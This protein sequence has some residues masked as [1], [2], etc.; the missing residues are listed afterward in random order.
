[1]REKEDDRI[2]YSMLLLADAK[3][4]NLTFNKKLQDCRS[5]LKRLEW[6]RDMYGGI[7][8]CPVCS[9]QKPKHKSNCELKELLS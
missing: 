8:Y 3:K 7:P 1:M 6:R 5:I 9:G 4:K 2:K